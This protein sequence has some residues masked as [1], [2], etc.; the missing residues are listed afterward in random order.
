M[1]HSQES[2]PQGEPMEQGVKDDGGSKCLLVMRGIGVE[3]SPRAKAS[4]LPS[5]VSSQ[6]NLA[7]FII[8]G[9]QEDSGN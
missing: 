8:E 5:G 9:E 3:T 6:E 4:P 2:E 1:S 7:S